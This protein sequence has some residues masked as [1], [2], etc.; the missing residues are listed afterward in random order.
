MQR[1]CSRR[2]M[3]GSKGVSEVVGTI[4]MLAVTVTLFSSMIIWVGTLSTPKEVAV[5]DIKGTIEPLDEAN[6]SAG[7][8]VKLVMR[9][10][11]PLLWQ[12]TWIYIVIDDTGTGLR[13]RDIGYGIDGPDDDWDTA[14]TWTYTIPPGG[15]NENSSVLAMVV[16]S[17]KSAVIWRA[18]LRPGTARN[19]PP[20][21]MSAWVDSSLATPEHES[22]EYGLDFYVFARVVDFDNNLNLSEAGAVW[23]NL[24]SIPGYGG[25]N[26]TYSDSDK[27]FRSSPISG[28]AEGDVQQGWY[29]I[30]IV[31]KDM[32]NSTGKRRVVVA[33]GGDIGE[34]PNPYVLEIWFSNELPVNGEKI[35]IYATIRN[36]GK[37]AA[38][39]NVSFY[40]GPESDGIYIGNVTNS[41]VPALGERDVIFRGWTA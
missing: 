18:D 16:D 1:R 31:A 19:Y 38:M 21:I 2:K 15:M 10:G 22:I 8:E 37:S 34:D 35:D 32:M 36:T 23:A 6:W 3:W 7:A 39:Y 11:P 41:S 14:E 27:L 40:D 30:E 28:P 12:S 26:L 4:L 20:V 29:T 17:V 33:I 24:S 5:A 13:T 9:G 25:V